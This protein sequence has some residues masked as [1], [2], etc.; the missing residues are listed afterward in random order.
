MIASSGISF[1][2]EKL[3]ITSPVYLVNY[4]VQLHRDGLS[5]S[6]RL[7]FSQMERG[8]TYMQRGQVLGLR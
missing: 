4:I 1:I 6:M 7:T 3:T 8:L 2:S 5:P